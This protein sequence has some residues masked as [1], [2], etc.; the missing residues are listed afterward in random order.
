MPFRQAHEIVGRIVRAA[1]ASHRSLA[2]LSLDELRA[3]SPVFEASAVGLSAEQIVA[4][5]SLVGGP[6]PAQA[7]AQVHAARARTTAQREWVATYAAR[8]PTL[9]SVTTLE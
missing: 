7:E 6:A 3:F 4:A 2:D 8:L 1:E 9:E 5:R